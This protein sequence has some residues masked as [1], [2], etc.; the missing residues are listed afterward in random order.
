L[1]DGDEAKAVPSEGREG[2]GGIEPTTGGAGFMVASLGRSTAATGTLPFTSGK[3]DGTGAAGGAAAGFGRATRVFSS[4][5][6]SA[7]ANALLTLL[8]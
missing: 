7:S 8:T 1:V 4:V 6:I 2:G 5:R 3:P